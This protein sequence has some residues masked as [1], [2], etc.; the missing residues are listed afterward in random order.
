MFQNVA[1]THI[2]A[3]MLVQFPSLLHCIATV[4][5]L[6]HKYSV[7]SSLTFGGLW[8][9]F[10]AQGSM[11]EFGFPPSIASAPAAAPVMVIAQVRSTVIGV[12][13]FLFYARSQFD[14][15]D[16][17]MAVMGTWAGLVD[18]YVVWNV[19]GSARWALFRFVSSGLIAAW[20][21]AGW[22]G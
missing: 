7:A 8:P 22:T 12:L 2:P 10:D 9:I 19:Q 15:V 20:G 6:K 18:S 3:L 17:V 21:Y 16:T 5:Q 1:L 11:L 4:Q 13:L 14:L